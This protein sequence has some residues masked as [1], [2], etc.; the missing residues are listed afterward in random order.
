LYNVF[1]KRILYCCLL[2]IVVFCARPGFTVAAPVDSLRYVDSLNDLAKKYQYRQLDTCFSYLVQARAIAQRL[3][4]TEGEARIYRTLGNYYSYRDNSYLS[5]RFYLDA[6]HLYRQLRDSAGISQ[7]SMQLAVYYEY[8]REHKEAVLYMHQAMQAARPLHNDTVMMP[9]LANYYFIYRN[10]SVYHA[11]AL[12]ALATAHLLA[13]KL[14]DESMWLYTGILQTSVL[15]SEGATN[16]AAQQLDSFV[17][18]A[19]AKGYVY[20]ALFGYAQMADDKAAQHSGDSVYYRQQ[21]V[22][23]AMST[24]YRELAAPY[25]AQLYAY[26][27]A[28]HNIDSSLYYSSMMLDITEKQEL[29]KTKGELDYI[30]YYL[31]ERTLRQLQL[32]HDY[33]QQVLDMKALSSRHRYILIIILVVVL[34]LVML[35]LTDV[36]RSYRYSKRNAAR[37][38]DKNREISEKNTLLHTQDDFK[39]KLISLIAHDFRSPL[40]HIIEITTLLKDHSLEYEGAAELFRKLETSSVHTL[41][42]FDNILRWIRSQLSGFVYV[43]QACNLR[44]MLAEVMVSLEEE[45]KDKTIHIITIIPSDLEILADR[46]MLQF[47]HRNLLHNA[48][49]FSTYGTVITVKAGRTN[50]NITFTV[51]DEGKGI[52]PEVLPWL[53]DYNRREQDSASKGAGLA[54][55]IC[56]D[57]MDKMGG[58]LTAENN[59]VRGATFSYTLPVYTSPA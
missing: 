19:L 3:H 50:D 12:K 49:C 47:V 1:N 59:P 13:T 22:K 31:Q 33:Q 34:L 44:V 17:K 20:H 57:F 4:Y 6:L 7:L 43:K 36:N 14:G 16:S 8:Q 42:V 37:L 48:I 54:L 30:D 5:F 52:S 21:M 45:Y 58:T 11:T 38:G 29:G 28:K 41:H 55:I 39:N 26:Y 2:A 53:F 27:D 10:D 25:V 18:H 40:N 56:K 9:I 15:M 32:E 24:G 51:C 23:L 46:E 35:L